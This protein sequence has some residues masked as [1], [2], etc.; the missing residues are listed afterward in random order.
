MY[1]S[2]H[3]AATM[4]DV[5]HGYGRDFEASVERL[6]HAWYRRKH[7]KGDRRRVVAVNKCIVYDGDTGLYHVQMGYLVEH[8]T[9][10]LD[11]LIVVN[12]CY[13]MGRVR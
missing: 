10:T 3:V 6:Y 12:V 13:K 5:G 8:N 1:V 9:Y 7:G 2:I 4:E 11:P